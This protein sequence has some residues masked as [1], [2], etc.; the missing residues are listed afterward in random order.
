M[1]KRNK[2]QEILAAHKARVGDEMKRLLQTENYDTPWSDAD[3]A[4]LLKARGLY[5]SPTQV[6]DLRR[7]LDIP[8]VSVRRIQLYEKQYKG[9]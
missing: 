4:R 5:T 8:A 7:E 1:R 9:K 3:L 2:S 6:Y